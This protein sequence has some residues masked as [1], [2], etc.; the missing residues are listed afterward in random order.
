[1][2]SSS[3]DL[4]GNDAM[5]ATIPSRLEQQERESAFCR[6]EV[7]D[8]LRYISEQVTETNGR[9]R[10]LERWRDT[11]KGKVVGVSVANSLVIT[12]LGLWVESVSRR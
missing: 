5:F 11:T 8:T 1:V 6:A 7:R 9:L 3:F 2:N 12:L 4:A 10:D